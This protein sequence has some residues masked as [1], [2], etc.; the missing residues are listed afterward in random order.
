VLE[1]NLL[2]TFI[3]AD[4]DKGDDSR[5]V[6]LYKYFLEDTMPLKNYKVQVAKDNGKLKSDGHFD[7]EEKEFEF[8]KWKHSVQKKPRPIDW[9]GT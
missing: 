3:E 2:K 1:W 6:F 5:C 9:I 7:Y 8:G 4:K